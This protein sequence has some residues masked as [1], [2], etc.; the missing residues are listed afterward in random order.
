MELK[1]NY[2]GANSFYGK[3]V[4]N[5]DSEGTHLLSYGTKVCTI[6]QGK[7]VVYSVDSATTLRHLKEYLK[8]AGF[9]ALNKGQIV[10]DYM[11]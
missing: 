3:A 5:E 10:R 6:T 11:K 7:A 1:P 4:I 2:D 9:K 8:Q